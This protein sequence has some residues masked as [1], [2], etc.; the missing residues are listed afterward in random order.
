MNISQKVGLMAGG[1]VLMAAVA[2]F[3][4]TQ[5]SKGAHFHELNALHLKYSIQL[6]ESLSA[7]HGAGDAGA[8]AGLRDIRA[9]VEGIRAQ[10]QGCLDAINIMDRVVMALIGTSHVYGICIDD[11]A[12]AEQALSDIDAFQRGALSAADF[13]T[14]IDKAN[15]VFA[16]NSDLFFQPVTDTVN[17]I[18]FAMSS[19]IVL[20]GAALS[21]TIWR[22]GKTGI[23]APILRIADAFE[24]L[25]NGDMSAETKEDADR[26]DE[27]GQIAATFNTFKN[28]LLQNEEL[29]ARTERENAE[30]TERATQIETLAN[31][32]DASINDM[33][34]GISTSAGEMKGTADALAETATKAADDV[35]SASDA[36]SLVTGDV[37]SVSTAA[38]ELSASIA[39][40][41]QQ[42]GGS[43]TLATQAVQEAQESNRLVER[44]ANNTQR[45]DDVVKL[46]ND[47]AE[48]TNLLALN[49]TIEA[50]RAGE[51]GK[52][53]AVV[54]NEVK[55]LASQTGKATEEIQQQIAAIQT[56]TKAAVTGIQAVSGRIE[57]ISS[58][59][60]EIASS[61]DEQSK[62]TRAI[63]ESIASAAKGTQNASRNLGDIRDIAEETKHASGEMVTAL[64]GLSGRTEQLRACVSA[65][66][67]DVKTA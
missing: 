47:I 7:F 45:V 3:A 32:F 41:S 64:K 44:L 4:V 51:A 29:N 21:L 6:N 9:A 43:A 30:R 5:V 38:E 20:V 12:A 39:R 55:S 59:S 58:V 57:E 22:F 46:I 34:S 49:A 36:A 26:K 18:V 27:V 2:V 10:P 37:D 61:V 8:R 42:V 33:L 1:V 56:D 66:L 13:S 48:Q 60:H 15:A 50:A 62:A 54:A 63:A 53:F 31:S 35:G 24:R 16:E 19:L 11:L 28:N 14:R 40:M 67:S 25:N 23:S 17:F 52:G 65:F